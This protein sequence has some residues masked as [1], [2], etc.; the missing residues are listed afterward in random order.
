MLSS[1]ASLLVV[2]LLLGGL[3]L[4]LRRWGPSQGVGRCLTVVDTVALGSGKSISVIKIGE[5]CFVV[6]ATPGSVSLISE[7]DAEQLPK[8]AASGRASPGLLSKIVWPGGA[9]A[10]D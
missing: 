4:W 9:R 10:E 5:R 3:L 1:V 7:F 6:A 2:L 8:V